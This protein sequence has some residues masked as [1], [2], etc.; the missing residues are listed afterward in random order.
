MCAGAEVASIIKTHKKHS[1][2]VKKRC[3][4]KLGTARKEVALA[5]LGCDWEHLAVLQTTESPVWCPEN[6]SEQ[7]PARCI[8]GLRD[9]QFLWKL[10]RSWGQPQRGCL[11]P[12]WVA[13]LRAEWGSQPLCSSCSLNQ[14][15]RWKG[16][17]GDLGVVKGF[18]FCL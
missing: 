4:K 8:A 12:L 7:M 18:G 16:K 9:A 17:A 15:Q 13:E 14:S 3:P 2:K 5:A 10:A 6:A 11:T 1:P